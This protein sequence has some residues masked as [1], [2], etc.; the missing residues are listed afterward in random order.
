MTDSRP[1]M[2][3]AVPGRICTQL[4]CGEKAWIRERF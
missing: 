3:G 4:F 1:V 2:A